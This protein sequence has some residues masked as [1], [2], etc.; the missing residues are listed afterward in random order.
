MP[1]P[2]EHPFNSLSPHGFHRVVYREWGDPDNARV[3]VCVHGL[4]RN[5]R[6]FDEL[7]TAISD[8]YRVL[9]PDMPGRGDSEWLRDPNDYRFPTYLTTLTAMLAH[10]HADRVAWVG[11]SM[12]GLLGMVMAAQPETPIARLV[13][14]DI[15]PVIEPAALARIGSYVGLDP[16]FESLRAAGSARACRCRR[17]SD[18]F[19]T[20]SGKRCRGALRGRRRR[21]LAAQIR[22][23][24]RS[25]FSSHGAG[26]GGDLWP[27]WDAIRARRWC[28]VAPSPTCLSAATAEAM[29]TRG[30][31]PEVI[32]FAGVGHAPMLLDRRSDRAGGRIP[33]SGLKHRSAAAVSEMAPHRLQ[34]GSAPKNTNVMALAL[35]LPSLEARPSNP[36]ETRLAR[37]QPWLDDMLKRDPIE[38][39]G[40]DRRRA[41]RHQS[42]FAV[43]IEAART[44]RK[45]LYDRADAVAGPRA[46]V[47]ARRASA[48]AAMRSKRPRHR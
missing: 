27:V 35:S 23:R 38:A 26:Q 30:P 28:C 2:R 29:H 37:V 20:S 21:P 48:D 43:R 39:A 10:A 24:H 17:L 45:I 16:V 19:P 3:V 1:S 14:N 15:G 7:A 8:R 4:T 12:G 18:R 6:D 44:R 42:R 13:V 25:A 31:K 40:V 33:G 22:S 34:S 41:G 46:P 5:G 36:P 11:T 9:C 47:F 32:E